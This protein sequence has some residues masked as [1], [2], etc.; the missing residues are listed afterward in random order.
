MVDE[1]T[2]EELYAQVDSVFRE[3]HPEAPQRLHRTK[4]EH[5]ELR[6]DWIFIRDT[7]LN[8]EVNRIY[9][10]T[11]PD[12]PHKIDPANPAHREF[13]DGW[14]EIRDRILSKSP[15]PEEDDGDGPAADEPDFSH[16]RAGV[17][18]ELLTWQDK[19]PADLYATFDAYAERAV[20]LIA[21][22]YLSNEVI[23]DQ[24]WRSPEVEFHAGDGSA[25][26]KVNAW[27]A[28]EHG[29]ANGSLEIELTQ[30]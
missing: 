25:S 7:L 24:L 29:V 28:W 17:Y 21:D 16:A 10:E 6:A 15:E 27:A 23:T 8:G 9:W 22:A 18:R 4:P 13:Q 1:P 11:Y 12:A 5:A 30:H 19:V 26:A 20:M 3:Q 2:R 14:L